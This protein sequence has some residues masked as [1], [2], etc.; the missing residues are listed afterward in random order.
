MLV[1]GLPGSRLRFSSVVGFSGVGCGGLGWLRVLHLSAFERSVLRDHGAREMAWMTCSGH[2]CGPANLAL[3][4]IVPTRSGVN[5]RFTQ[6][7]KKVKL[8]QLTPI[9]IASRAPPKLIEEQTKLTSSPPHHFATFPRIEAGVAGRQ[10]LAALQAKPVVFAVEGAPVPQDLHHHRQQ[11]P[12]L[13]CFHT[14]SGLR[15]RRA[16]QH[17]HRETPDWLLHT[18]CLEDV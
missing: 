2:L 8:R 12:S 14:H 3:I 10:R 4:P 11:M 6:V 9:R 13:C 7:D 17:G 1:A 5:P 18:D 15:S 16:S